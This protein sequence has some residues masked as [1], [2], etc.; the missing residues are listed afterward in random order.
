MQAHLK[1]L[2]DEF[3]ELVAGRN[4]TLEIGI[5]STEPDILRTVERDPHLA[6]LPETVERLK[7]NRVPFKVSL[8]YGLPGQT[9]LSCAQML[10]SLKALGLREEQILAYPLNL[11]PGSALAAQKDELKVEESTDLVPRV[12][13]SRS[14]DRRQYERMMQLFNDCG[15]REQRGSLS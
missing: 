10:D 6:L 1:H 8:I 7:A 3:L 12:V 2:P 14:F 15:P 9:F 4:V 11:L 13:A 5:Q